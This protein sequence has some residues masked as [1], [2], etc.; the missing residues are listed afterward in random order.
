[1]A[2]RTYFDFA[3][4]DRDWFMRS[5]EQGVAAN[6]MAALA[7]IACE[8][9]LKHLIDVY[10]VP[11]DRAEEDARTSAMHTHNLAELTRFIRYDMGL[12]LDEDAEDAM[13]RINGFYF[14]TRYPG[15]ESIEVDHRDIEDCARAIE[16]CRDETL[17]LIGS[18]EACRGQ[19]APDGPG[20][21]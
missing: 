21:R 2:L 4:D 9:Y 18:I 17:R 14:T 19:D 15:D 11:E 5:Y 6:G 1:M 7:Q 13:D 8:E 16:S 20:G 10:Y 3:E 12:D